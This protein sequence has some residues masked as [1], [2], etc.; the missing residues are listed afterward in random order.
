M[1]AV[2]D[3]MSPQQKKMLGYGAV[4]VVAV[5]AV[6]KITGGGEEVDED[7]P[8]PTVTPI[9]PMPSTDAIGVGELSSIVTAI[10]D[11]LGDLTERII[12]LED[13]PPTS[14]Q[15]D[16][17]PSDSN[18]TVPPELQS[19]IQRVRDIFL[20]RGV[21][22]DYSISPTGESGT[23][24]IERL[25]RQ[26]YENDRTYEDI[27]RS[28]EY[29]ARH[30]A[31]GTTSGGTS[32]G[33]TTT[34]PPTSTTSALDAARAWVAALFASRGVPLTYH[35]TGATEDPQARLTRLANQLVSGQ[36]TQAQIT[37]SV[38]YLARQRAS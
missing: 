33:T 17:D 3:R 15:P 2:L 28:V 10:T 19:A 20:Q 12:F 16:P 14:A 8:L 30:R 38:D 25:A 26:L 6:R 13:V 32:G 24:R 18:P 11:K 9:Q 23:A 35:A 36:R 27:V 22:F 31:G 5:V 21:P 1:V 4:G 34:R 29:L 37:A 7:A